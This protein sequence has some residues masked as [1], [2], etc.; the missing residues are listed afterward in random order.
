MCLLSLSDSDTPSTSPQGK[1]SSALPPSGSP[2]PLSVPEANPEV[3]R[4]AVA[5]SVEDPA[6]EALSLVKSPNCVTCGTVIALKALDDAFGE[7]SA[8]GELVWERGRKNDARF[9]SL[10][11][12]Y[13]LVRARDRAALAGSG[14]TSMSQFF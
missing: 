2:D 14:A 3:L 6:A 9:F 10:G 11:H 12:E 1:H 4:E 5:R 7:D 8:L 13:V